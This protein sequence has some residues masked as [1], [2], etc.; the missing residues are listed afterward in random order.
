MERFTDED[1]YGLYMNVSTPTLVDVYIY[2]KH[3]TV[4][5]THKMKY[6]IIE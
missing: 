5:P 6:I 1:D 3:T 4:S 2:C